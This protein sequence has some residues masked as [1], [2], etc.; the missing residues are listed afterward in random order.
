MSQHRHLRHLR[1]WTRGAA[2]GATVAML[3]AAL[4]AGTGAAAGAAKSG[5][6]VRFGLEAESTGGYC[7]PTSQLA[8]SGIQV[9]AAVYDTLTAPNSKGK[10]VPNLA[11]SVTPNDTF[12]EWTIKVRPGITFHDGTPLNGA[13]VTTNIEAWRK[14][15]LFSFVFS[16]IASVTTVDDLTVKVT[17]KVPWQAFP[18]YLYL[19]GRAGIVAPAQLADTGT[20]A[21]N[22]IGTGPFKLQEWKTN[23]SLTVVRNPNYWKKDAKGK[24]LPYL[25]KITFVPVVD[26][27]A[28]QN[29][30]EGGQLNLMHTSAADT[31]EALKSVKGVTETIEPPGNRDVRYYLLNTA[32]APFDN[33]DARRALAYAINVEEINQIRNRGLFDVAD[34]IIDSKAQGYLKNSGVPTYNLKKAK[35]LVDKVKAANG[36]FDV[37]FLTTNDSATLAEAQLLV[38]QAGKAGI[39]ASLNQVDQSALINTALGG[40]FS[41]LLWRNFHSD[42]SYGDAGNYVWWSTGSPIN[43]GKINSPDVQA[44]LDAGRTAQDTADGNSAYQDFN[45]AMMASP[46]VIPAWFVD[47]TIAAKGVGGVLGAPLPDGSK[48][49]FMY[50]RIPVD[51]LYLT[52]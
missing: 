40:N 37:T 33:A 17:T 42:P 2:I 24:Q 13:A 41:V 51:G 35:A 19:V 12:N 36:S 21:R 26:T 44:A 16:N 39:S 18:A 3:S 15:T 49:K 11:E 46:F 30:L 5:G 32:K 10:Y 47:W 27:T 28:R 6:E 23:E 25:D 7:L 20:C 34:S 22:L 50:G 4:V 43:F 48:P 52:K 1:G 14:G 45:K 31:I 29:Q 9:A 8:I 38:E